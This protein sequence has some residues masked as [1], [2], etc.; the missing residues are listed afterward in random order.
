[1]LSQSQALDVLRCGVNVFLTGEPGSGKTY[2]LNL[3]LRW[4]RERGIDRAVTASTGIA[5]THLGGVTVHAWCGIGV[6]TDIT[7]ARIERI[8]EMAFTVRRVRAAKVLVIDEV[9][10]LS[11]AT[12][13]AVDAAC[14]GLRDDPRPFGGMQVV[15]VGDFFQLPPVRRADDDAAPVPPASLDDFAFTSAAWREAKPVVCYLGEQHRQSDEAFL[16]LL[17]ALRARGVADG[18][19]RTLDARCGRGPAPGA[20]LLYA[21]N[22]DVDRINDEELAKLP[23]EAREFA[24]SSEGPERLVAM[25]SRGCTSPATLRLKRG[26]RVVFTRNDTSEGRWVNGTLGEVAGFEDGLPVVRT[27]D[28]AR[29]VVEPAEWVFDDGERVLAGIRQI[30]LRLAWAITVHK[31]QGMSLDAAHVDLSR[32]FAYGQGY[33]ALSRARTLEGLT[34][35]GYNDRALE[36]H[37]GVAAKDAEFRAR[38]DALRRRLVTNTPEA[39]AA[40][41]DAFVLAS[42]GTLARAA[43][44]K[45]GRRK[46]KK[47]EEPRSPGERRWERTIELVREGRSIADVARERGR[48]PGTILGHIENAADAGQLRRGDLAHVARAEAAM[49]AEVRDAVL[50][51]PSGKL[52]PLFDRFGGRYDFDRL[53]LARLL[54]R[55]A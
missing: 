43:P 39:L 51:A 42:G 5:A 36:V 35:V 7:P 24:M 32:A 15:F 20:V 50:E 26:A 44:P 38:S 55:F 6:R 1:M 8:K 45:K 41:R 25:L 47:P 9:S 48:T 2:T 3:Y 31:S 4:L 18:H 34:L 11:S 22:A 49:L 30:P 40:R 17:A 37:P 46:K 19:R 27:R 13:D 33:V 28:G 14:R 12:L 29:H 54:V 16:G 23:G 21:H 53:R 10:M 52:R